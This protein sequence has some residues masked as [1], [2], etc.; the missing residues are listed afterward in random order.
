[1][2]L[3]TRP[4]ACQVM[5][6]RIERVALNLTEFQQ[7]HPAT[8]H[9]LLKNN[10]DL[11]VSLRGAVFF[12]QAKRGLDQVS[13]S[14]IYDECRNLLAKVWGLDFVISAEIG[15]ISVSSFSRR[16]ICKDFAKLRRFYRLL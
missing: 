5:C 3:V 16:F 9:A 8:Q 1:M 4:V 15:K 10:T 14:L 11:I 12:D 7:L 13:T 6:R 2:E